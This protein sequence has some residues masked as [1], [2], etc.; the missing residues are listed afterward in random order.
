MAKKD[1]SP[2]IDMHIH[3]W[4]SP[5]ASV[6]PAKINDVL[7]AKQL[8]G[9]AIVDHDTFKGC[10]E[11]RKNTEKIVVPGMEISTSSGE[12]LALF[13][14]EE[15]HEKELAV[16]VD[17]VREQGGL[18]IL[19]HPFDLFRKRTFHVDRFSRRELREMVD[20]IE[21]LNSRCLLNYFNDKARRL[22]DD[23]V[24]PATAG[25]DAHTSYEIGRSYT[26][27]DQADSLEDVRKAV[28][29]GATMPAGGLSPFFVHF[30][31]TLRK[32]HLMMNM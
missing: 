7:R 4:Y 16:V 3:T 15:I 27:F 20:A 12:I 18:V 1:A 30:F 32:H 9:V 14:Q 2:R 21:V 31:S 8:D 6:D 29:N 17:K 25:S 24:K 26:I 22:A 23:L 5:D 19:P 11:A 28:M 10:L 13:L